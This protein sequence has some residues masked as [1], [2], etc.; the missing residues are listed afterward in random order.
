MAHSSTGTEGDIGPIKGEGSTLL[1]GDEARPLA[2]GPRELARAPASHPDTP[3]G[4]RPSLAQPRLSLAIGHPPTL[5]SY[6]SAEGRKAWG[7]AWIQ[8]TFCHFCQRPRVEEH[9]PAPLFRATVAPESPCLRA[10]ERPRTAQSEC[11]VCVCMRACVCIT[12]RM[13][14]RM[15]IRRACV[16]ACALCEVYY[17]CVYKWYVHECACAISV[18]VSVYLVCVPT[19]EHVI[20]HGVSVVWSAC[21]S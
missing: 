17:A 12:M 15:C 1:G 16:H 5:D 21:S 10:A 8:G 3:T 14:L 19:C 11:D 2:K 7:P 18:C 4:A 13:H 20:E 6:S 9:Q